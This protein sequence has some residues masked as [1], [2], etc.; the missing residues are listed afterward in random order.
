MCLTQFAL[1]WILMFDAVT[2]A[3]PGA[4]RPAQAEE[5][6]AASDQPVLET[7]VMNRVRALYEARIRPQVHHFW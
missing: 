3:I 1:R 7:D 2:C 6:I 5:N 4:K